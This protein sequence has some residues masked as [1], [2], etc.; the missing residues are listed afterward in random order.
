MLGDMLQ[1]V[2]KKK[3]RVHCLAN[4]VT[5]N[6]CANI[7]LAAGGYPIMADDAMEAAEITACCDAL[8]LNLG[9]P[10]GRRLEAM[11]LSAAQARRMDI[12]VILDPVG[13]TASSVRRRFAKELMETGGIAVIRGNAPEIAALSGEAF[14]ASGVDAPGEQ[15]LEQA[16]RAAVRLAGEAG[17]VVA[18]TGETDVVTDGRHVF[19]IQNG[20]PVMK[21]ITGAG[22]QLSALMGA[23][24]AANRERLLE[25]AA[26]A[27]CMMGLC[28]E[29][30]AGRMGAQ[31]GNASCRSFVIDAAYRMTG[32]RLKEGARIEMR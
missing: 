12:P 29:I 26:A 13:V 2:R 10:S 31:D 17:A 18:L 23:F 3:P 16:M 20:H 5:A 24:A 1:N 4:L 28:G 9:T 30:A 7:L 14:R 32:N 6:D 21:T 25:A 22:C 11:R 19:L 27:V 15:A 8:V